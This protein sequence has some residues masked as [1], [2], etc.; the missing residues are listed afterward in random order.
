MAR[1]SAILVLPTPAFAGGDRDYPGIGAGGFFFSGIGTS[2]LVFGVNAQKGVDCAGT[3]YETV[4]V[5]DFFRQLGRI[6]GLVKPE[7]AFFQ[8]GSVGYFLDGEQFVHPSAVVSE[9]SGSRPLA[10]PDATTCGRQ[11]DEPKKACKAR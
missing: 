7:K 4:A 6:L 5:Q 10:Y 1:L 8:A 9:I 2:C 3:E 11:R